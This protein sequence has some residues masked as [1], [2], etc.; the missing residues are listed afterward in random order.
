MDP[1]RVGELPPI[2]R[3][4]EKRIFDVKEKEIDINKNQSSKLY[5]AKSK[6]IRADQRKV[7]KNRLYYRL[8]ERNRQRVLK[9]THHQRA[10]KK[11]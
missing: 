2:I 4:K 6:L 9:N 11:K 8:K 5:V 1:K 7:S 10:Q 3:G